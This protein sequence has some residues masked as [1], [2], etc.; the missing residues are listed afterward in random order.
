MYRDGFHGVTAMTFV[1]LSMGFGAVLVAV[2]ES[3]G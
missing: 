2:V 1:V 3:M